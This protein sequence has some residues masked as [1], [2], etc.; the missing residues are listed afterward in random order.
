MMEGVLSF[1]RDIGRHT[2]CSQELHMLTLPAVLRGLNSG[3]IENQ[4]LRF[5]VA[6]SSLLLA[7]A[8]AAACVE[9]EANPWSAPSARLDE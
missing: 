5:T 9:A 1:Q 7:F 3:A 8:A 6:V 4:Q 2:L